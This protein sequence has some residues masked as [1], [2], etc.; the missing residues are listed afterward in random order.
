MAYRNSSSYSKSV[1]NTAGYLKKCERLWAVLFLCL[2]PVCFNIKR[3]LEDVRFWESE[4]FLV[5]QN[6][7][8]V[9]NNERRRRRRTWA[10]HTEEV[11]PV[12]LV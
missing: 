10:R 11:V 1:N 2:N 6:K 4:L 12:M 5:I 7:P 8:V 3:S 9:A